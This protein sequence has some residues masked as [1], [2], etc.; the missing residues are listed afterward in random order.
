MSA[1][2]EPSPLFRRS[3]FC[4]DGGCVEVAAPTL[5]EF[6]IRD[7]KDHRPDA[8]ALRFNRTEWV[9]FLSGVEAGEFAPS[10]LTRHH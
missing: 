2:A 10:A 9:A 3:S 1:A 5:D 7:A 8:P 6:I 4:G